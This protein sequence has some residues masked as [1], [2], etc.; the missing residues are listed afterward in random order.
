MSNITARQGGKHKY[1]KTVFLAF[2]FI[3]VLSFVAILEAINMDANQALSPKQQSIITIAAFTANGDQQKL[4]TALN[5][6]LNAGLT[7]N[8]IK[9]IRADVRLCRISRSLN[10]INTFMAP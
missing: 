5:E 4:K 3:F 8:E 10:G 7:I 6:G 9:E 1:E 2:I